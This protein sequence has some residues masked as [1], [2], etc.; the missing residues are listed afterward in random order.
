MPRLEDGTPLK[1]WVAI[2][3]AKFHIRQRRCQP[4]L[5][6]LNLTSTYLIVDFGGYDYWR[7]R[8]LAGTARWRSE[9]VRFPLCASPSVEKP[10][11]LNLTLT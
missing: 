4:N 11:G 8:I 9:K 5:T 10:A 7:L 3:K 1:R 6:L 2:I